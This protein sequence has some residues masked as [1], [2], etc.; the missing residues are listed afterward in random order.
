MCP[1]KLAGQAFDWERVWQ[2]AP[3][4]LSLSPPRETCQVR[5]PTSVPWRSI[6]FLQNLPYPA[7]GLCLVGWGRRSLC[8]QRKARHPATG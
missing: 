2:V 8:L 1:G 6:T 4:S 3:A 5:D 7:W